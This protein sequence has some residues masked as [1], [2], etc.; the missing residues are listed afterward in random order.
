MIREYLTRREGGLGASPKIQ[1][2]SYVK[3]K[4]ISEHTGKELPWAGW[5]SSLC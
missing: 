4:L 1:P 3:A 2:C 5:G